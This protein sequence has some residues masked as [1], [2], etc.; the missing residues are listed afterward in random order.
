M[1]KLIVATVV[2][3]SLS[4]VAM[5]QDNTASPQRK[6]INQSPT[7]GSYGYQSNNTGSLDNK[8]SKDGAWSGNCIQQG[9]SG[10]PSSTAGTT[11]GSG[12]TVSNC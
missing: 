12:T 5:P 2:S 9:N 1:L 4:S 6:P 8:D 10:A 7:T 11:D 3:A